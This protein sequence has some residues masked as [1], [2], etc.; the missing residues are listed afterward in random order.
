MVCFHS[1]DTFCHLHDPLDKVRVILSDSVQVALNSECYVERCLGCFNF[2]GA[3]E[4]FNILE[5]GQQR[6]LPCEKIRQSAQPEEDH[7]D[8]QERCKANTGNSLD[9]RLPIES[10]CAD[11]DAEEVIVKD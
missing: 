10:E 3:V 1:V 7:Q 9:C 6:V 8:H 11:R 4:R 2:F 5:V